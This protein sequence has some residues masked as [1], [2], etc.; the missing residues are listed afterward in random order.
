LLQRTVADWVYGKFSKKRKQKM[1]ED[2]WAGLDWQFKLVHAVAKYPVELEMI[3][4]HNIELVP[5]ETVLHDL[6]ATDGEMRGYSGTD[7]LEIIS[8]YDAT[9]LRKI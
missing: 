5:L 4:S 3:A 1:R 2:R 7:I 9:K 6:E 8:Y